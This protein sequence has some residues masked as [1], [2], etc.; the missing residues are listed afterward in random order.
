MSKF[1]WEYLISIDGSKVSF[2]RVSA[3][4]LL[5]VIIV[6]ELI[7]L[8]KTGR[9]T[10]VPASLVT[11]I[12]LLLGYNHASKVINKNNN[13]GTQTGNSQELSD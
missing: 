12:G 7:A 13:A 5:I 9:F 6:G 8:I 11:L 4:L 2:G 1:H 3:A 10:D